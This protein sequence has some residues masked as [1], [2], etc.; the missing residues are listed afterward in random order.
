MRT[1]LLTHLRWILAAIAL[2]GLCSAGPAAGLRP[3]AAQSAPSDGLVC[4]S[5]G[6]NPTFTLTTQTGYIGTP[7]DNLLFMWGYSEGSNAFQY[8]G[9]VLCVNEGD[10]VTVILN[11]TLPEATSIV[12]PG[13]T[14]VLAN[15]QLAQPQFSGATLT[16][17]TN[18]AAANGGS[19]TYSFV[20]DEPGTYLYQS[21]T[22]PA[23]QVRMGLF[24]ALIVRPSLGANFAYNRADSQFNPNT[25]YLALL[26]EVDPYLSQ[27]VEAGLPFNM[28]NYHPRYWLINGRGFPDSIAANYATW[29]TSQPYGA[30]VRIF[31]YDATTNPQPAL[32]RYLNVG[33]EDFPLHPHGNNGRLIG[34]DGQPLAAAGGEDLSYEKFTFR[35]GPGQT[36]D[37]L[38][39]WRDAEQY[40]PTTN[41]VPSTIPELQN[42]VYG[43]FYGG[44]PYLGQQGPI[45][46]GTTSD[47][48]CGEYY[49]ISHNHALHQLSSWGVLMTGPASFMRIDPPL[50]NACP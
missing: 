35:V 38:F 31:P 9:P 27:A 42:I 22:D 44:S 20:A 23:K 36:W 19:V 46:V 39:Q 12:F 5:A 48:Q 10:T 26:S 41:M 13:Q 3:A 32:M 6:P 43:M 14:A 21:G 29:L 7:D 8:P 15:G 40:N 24:G 28:N 49:I 16:S 34:R 30:L 17:L 18:V 25:E 4:T 33:S 50:P 2:I 45:P 47:N 37:V 11:N 1:H